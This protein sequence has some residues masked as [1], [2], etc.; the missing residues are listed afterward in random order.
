MRSIEASTPNPNPT[1]NPTP[2]PGPNQERQLDAEEWRQVLLALG[3]VGERA[4]GGEVRREARRAQKLLREAR[5][6]RRRGHTLGRPGSD[7]AGLAASAP[8]W[9]RAR[10]RA[11]A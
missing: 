3:W 8:A 9:P 5:M 11:T 10:R 4:A 2:N 7:R 6:A 1:P